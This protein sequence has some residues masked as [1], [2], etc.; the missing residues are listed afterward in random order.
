MRVQDVM[1]KDVE[2]ISP[3]QSAAWAW[4]RMRTR[5]IHHLVITEGAE[6]VGV[7]SDRDMGGRNGGSV[8]NDRLVSE[9]MTDRVVTISPTVTVRRAAN[10]MRG[11]SIGC[12]VVAEQNRP[13]GI[14]TVADLLSLIGRGI[15]RPVAT[16]QR[17]SLNH[18]VPHR[19]R[20]RST[21]V[22]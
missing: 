14:V 2:T 4:N 17:T 8:R 13:V 19:K 21:G 11:R 20:S 7:L 15:E 1:T 22:W 6:I 9:L 18:R 3:A 5:G 16:T 12:L 10:L